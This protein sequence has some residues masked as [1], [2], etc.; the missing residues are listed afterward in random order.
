[1]SLF[2]HNPY[3]VI[4]HNLTIALFLKS[5][6]LIELWLLLFT[7]L[8]IGLLVSVG[9]VDVKRESLTPV[10]WF[11][12]SYGLGGISLISSLVTIFGSCIIDT[13][14]DSVTISNCPPSLGKM[15]SPCFSYSIISCSHILS[16]PSN[17][18]MNS[19]TLYSP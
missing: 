2:W 1:M 16:S 15:I 19:F 12:A 10:C 17:Y 11:R 13:R 3:V 8:S 18:F 5:I 4:N 9:F 6:R 14:C 7:L